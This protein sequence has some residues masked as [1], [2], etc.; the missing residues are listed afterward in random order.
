MRGVQCWAHFAL[1]EHMPRVGGYCAR[2]AE[3]LALRP[4]AWSWSAWCLWQPM[5]A[6]GPVGRWLAVPGLDEKDMYKVAQNYNSA[7]ASTT[8]RCGTR[9][10]PRLSWCACAK[11]FQECESCGNGH[12]DGEHHARSVQLPSDNNPPFVVSDP[13]NLVVARKRPTACL[14]CVHERW[15]ILANNSLS[16]KNGTG[17]RRRVDSCV[18]GV[19]RRC[20]NAR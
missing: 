6:S 17:N 12:V 19:S 8:N 11:V 1:D 10:C 20:A 16:G 5:Q 18:M 13:P 7:R 9:E 14:C 15:C 2:T 4:T 3:Q